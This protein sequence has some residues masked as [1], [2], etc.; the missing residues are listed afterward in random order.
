MSS[1]DTG[2]HPSG[3]WIDKFAISLAMLCAVHC[4]LMPVVILLLPIIATSFFVHQ[5]F[6]LW[7]L[8]LVI[9]T[10]SLTIFLGCR[11]HKDKWVFALSATGLC[12]LLY[13]VFYERMVVPGTL[14]ESAATDACL[15]CLQNLSEDGFSISSVAWLNSIGGLFLASGHLRNFLLCRKSQCAQ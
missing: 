11:R 8:F 10:T 14:P 6:H 15:H 7:M 1:T 2:C 12:F 9:P 13:V 3:G 5:D 4:L